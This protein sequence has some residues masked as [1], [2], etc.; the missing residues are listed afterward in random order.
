MKNNKNILFG[1]LLIALIGIDQLAKLIV[2]KQIYNSY[3]VVIKNM[4]NLTYIENTGGAYGIGNNNLL[5]FIIGNFILIAI[6]IYILT[7]KRNELN[8]IMKYALVLIISGGCGNLIDRIFRG[9]VVDY[10][11]INPI[12]KFPMFNLADICITCGVGLVAICLIKDC[13]MEKE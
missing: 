4:L 6:L 10:I 3:I 9:F 13:I 8:I 7:K 12:I 11:D 1:G 2:S 5:V